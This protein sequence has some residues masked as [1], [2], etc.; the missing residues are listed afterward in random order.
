[1]L[2][3]TERAFTLPLPGR[4]GELQVLLGDQGRVDYGPRLGEAKGLIGPARTAVRSLDDWRAAPLALAKIGPALAARLRKAPHASAGEPVTGPCFRRA[5]FSTTPG[6][7]HFLRTDGW[8]RGLAWNGVLLGPYSSLGPTRTLYV[9]GPLVAGED[10]LVLLELH[11]GGRRP[12]VVAAP[13]LGVA[14]L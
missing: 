12:G 14:E 2:S 11:G 13:D 7:D 8:G 9:P 10:E 6:V 3:R 5:V 1:M 4:D